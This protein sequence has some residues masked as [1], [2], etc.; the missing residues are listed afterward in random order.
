MKRENN[1][2]VS[3]ILDKMKNMDDKNRNKELDEI[4]NYNS[5]IKLYI[6]MNPF[7]REATIKPSSE[8]QQ[9]WKEFV[10]LNNKSKTEENKQRI[11]DILGK[12]KNMDDKNRNKELDEIPIPITK[13]KRGG[14]TKKNKRKTKKNKRKTKKNKRKTKRRL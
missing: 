14:K 4:P 10:V 5:K 3:H 7:K 1:E 6:Y 9:L 12:I 11:S 2:K 8:R 13:E